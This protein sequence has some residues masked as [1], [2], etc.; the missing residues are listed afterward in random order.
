MEA[1]GA[2]FTNIL[3][4]YSRACY[5]VRGAFVVHGGETS[6]DELT[7]SVEMLSEALTTFSHFK[8]TVPA[9]WMQLQ[10]PCNYRSLVGRMLWIERCCRRLASVERY[11][12][13]VCIGA[14]FT[15]M[16]YRACHSLEQI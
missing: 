12:D 13:G 15:G 16:Q 7:S 8:M 11:V 6:R 14:I 3:A 2:C 4:R 10:L 9:S 5:A 1:Y